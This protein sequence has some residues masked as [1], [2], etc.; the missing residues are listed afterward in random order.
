MI[1]PAGGR[2]DGDC[3]PRQSRRRRASVG[4]LVL[5][6]QALAQR[7]IAIRRGQVIHQADGVALDIGAVGVVEPERR[8]PL[9]VAS[10]PRRR[11]AGGRLLQGA[12]AGAHVLPHLIQ[13]PVVVPCP[14]E[15]RV[16]PVGFGG[17]GLVARD[18]AVGG[19]AQVVR[20][21][22]AVKDHGRQGRAAEAKDAMPGGRSPQ[23]HENSEPRRQAHR[24]RLESRQS[25]PA[26]TS[27]APGGDGVDLAHG[28]AAGPKEIPGQGEIQ[29]AEGGE[30]Q[31]LARGEPVGSHTCL[32][33]VRLGDVST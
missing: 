31:Q 32:Q 20:E 13:H 2:G 26:E 8:Q 1:V 10:L 30:G 16:K 22:G 18:G 23:E 27:Q 12:A 17:Y 3:A 25:P 19:V 15:S 14:L 21:V 7:P 5:G 24:R 29:P 9:Q 28:P 6:P 33:R 4:R 11:Q